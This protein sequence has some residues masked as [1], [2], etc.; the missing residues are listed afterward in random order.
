MRPWKSASL[1]HLL[2]D[3]HDES[4]ADDAHQ[5]GFLDEVGIAYDGV[6]PLG[7]HCLQTNSIPTLHTFLQVENGKWKYNCQGRGALC[8]VG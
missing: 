2:K 5:K 1:L 3:I 4:V 6:S 7:A 8:D